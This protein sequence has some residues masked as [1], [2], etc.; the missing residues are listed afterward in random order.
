MPERWSPRAESCV[1]S[2]YH[3][4][5]AAP[6]LPIDSSLFK[7][8]LRLAVGLFRGRRLGGTDP[9]TCVPEPAN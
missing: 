7:P 6:V 4:S 5:V 3:H 8:G 1:A 2:V 9:N